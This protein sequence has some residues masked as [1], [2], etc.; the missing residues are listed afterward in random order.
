MICETYLF[1][2]DLNLLFLL[3][4]ESLVDSKIVS[5]THELF[6]SLN[7]CLANFRSQAF[8]RWSLP[9]ITP[10]QKLIYASVLEGAEVVM[11][12]AVPFNGYCIYLQIFIQSMLLIKI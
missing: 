1:C 12:W 7:M 4:H 3:I 6:K 9:Q 5:F 10:I 11:S 2:F 8:N